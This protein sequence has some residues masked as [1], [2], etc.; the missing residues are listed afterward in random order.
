MSHTEEI[1]GR[2]AAVF[3]NPNTSDLHGFMAEFARAIHGF[4]PEQIDK[5]VTQGIRE[6]KFF[7]RPAEVI[8]IVRRNNPPKSVPENWKDYPE[9][10]PP[11]AEEKAR[12]RALMA[13]LFRH[14]DGANKF[15][16]NGDPVPSMDVSREAFERL[17]R[18]SRNDH[19]H[20]GPPRGKMAA[21]GDA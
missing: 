18:N 13:N 2:L 17:Q 9:P 4:D 19:L 16:L 11:T 7:P 8:E 6:W 5:A 20:G 21:A 1:I 3:G 14:M 15:T 10:P 12:G